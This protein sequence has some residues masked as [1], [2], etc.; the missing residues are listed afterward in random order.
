MS[1][2]SVTMPADEP[3]PDVS[4]KLRQARAE[5]MG[6]RGPG[7][8]DTEVAAHTRDRVMIGGETATRRL[9]MAARQT[10]YARRDAAAI[11]RTAQLT[12]AEL[13]ESVAQLARRLHPR[14]LLP[15]TGTAVHRRLG[16]HPLP[17]V[18]GCV[19]LLLVIRRK[20]RVSRRTDPR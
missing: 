18:L 4:E 13:A 5:L 10:G 16:A 1:P 17:F 14:R 9:E 15:V 3:T 11:T 20:H 2:G 6:G 8:G 12:R 19:A 7:A